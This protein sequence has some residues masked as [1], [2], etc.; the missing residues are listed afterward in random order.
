MILTLYPGPSKS[1][2]IVAHE[3][4]DAL[5]IHA[6]QSIPPPP[7]EP[8]A[9][10]IQTPTGTHSLGPN[11]PK[12]KT[13]QPTGPQWRELVVSP[14]PP[15]MS[16]TDK[17][18]EFQLTLSKQ[19]TPHG[20]YLPMLST[21]YKSLLETPGNIIEV[22]PE[23]QTYVAAIATRIGGTSQDPKSTP[24]GAA[25]ILDYGTADTVPINSLRG[26]R[27]HKRVSPFEAPG[28]V[29]L[30]ADVDFMALAEAA[31]KASP[32]VEVHGPVEQGAFLEVMGIKERAEML[33]RNIEKSADE[34]DATGR[35]ELEEKK[36]GID[37]A[38]RRLVDRSPVGMGKVYKVMAI[39]PENG[40]KKLVGFGGDV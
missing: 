24:L 8:V 6:F 17:K 18:E 19:A 26:I 7:E 25:L 9:N 1:P 34:V 20:M 27:E 12:S 28:L 33:V 35:K 29:D 13:K 11:A 32:G 37:G 3:F 5:P 14:T 4:F 10:N 22:S 38:W 16:P 30:S 23:S 39:T 15:P 31:L 2:F 21:R 40:G 36:K